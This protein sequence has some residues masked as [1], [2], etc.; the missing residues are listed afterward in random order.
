MATGRTVGTSRLGSS[1]LRSLHHSSPYLEAAQ[2]LLK[3]GLKLVRDEF[4]GTP[5]GPQPTAVAR[6]TRKLQDCG[7]V[8]NTARKAQYLLQLHIA[9]LVFLPWRHTYNN[10]R[11]EV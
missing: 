7:L 8:V 3:L 6:T 5:L 4:V 2:D 11:N 9:K 10:S 1:C